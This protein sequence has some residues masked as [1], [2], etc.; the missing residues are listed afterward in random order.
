MD[1]AK[2]RKVEMSIVVSVDCCI[3]GTLTNS[4][5]TEIFSISLREKDGTS[6]PF[7]EIVYEILGRQV[8][9]K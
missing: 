4:G 3:C 2:K 6:I 5:M 9:I 8:R 1:S 7:H